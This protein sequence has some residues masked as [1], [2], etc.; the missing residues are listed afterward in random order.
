MKLRPAHAIV[1][2][3][4]IAAVVVPLAA[5]KSPPLGM[6]QTVPPG[7]GPV[8]TPQPTVPC[9]PVSG[10]GRA[11]ANRVDF[12]WAYLLRFCNGSAVPTPP[13][14]TTFA[15]VYGN[16]IL[17]TTPATFSGSATKNGVAIPTEPLQTLIPGERDLRI[18]QGVVQD[19][20]IF[21]AT[22]TATDPAG[23]PRV[24]GDGST[25]KVLSASGSC[26]QAT[27]LAPTIP[28]P[29]VSLPPG[30]TPSIPPT[31]FSFPPTL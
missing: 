3:A 26:P 10:C 27:P 30:V 5:L 14:F 7:G 23:N 4:L 11:P 31:S 6:G 12:V 29:T 8:T 20:D 1:P 24:F 15:L 17:A 2:L 13:G 25:V 22:L 16:G 9:T 28:T 19:G 18:R 21:T